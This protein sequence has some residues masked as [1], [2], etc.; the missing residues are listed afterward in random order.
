MDTV[1]V[2]SRADVLNWIW[3]SLLIVFVIYAVSV[4]AG[5]VTGNSLM[6][7][8]AAAWFNFLVPALFGVFIAYFSHYLYGFNPTGSWAD[9][10]MR[11]SPY[12]NVFQ[13]KGHFG[14]ASTIYYI[15]SFIILYGI[16]SFLYQKRRLEHATDS[17]AFGFMEPIICYLIAFLSV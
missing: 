14:I 9:F 4:F 13:S 16:T 10:G 3:T 5:I 8:A 7:F 2:F 15:V 12:L 17:L 6:H 11:I 1:N